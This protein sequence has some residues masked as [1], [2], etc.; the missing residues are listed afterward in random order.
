MTSVFIKIVNMSISASWLIL[1]IV[2][3]RA[4]FQKAPKKWLCALW[5]LVAFRLIFP[6]SIQ[7][8][9]SLMPSTETIPSNISSFSI[10]TIDSGIKVF[11]QT[12]DHFVSDVYK[13]FS[14]DRGNPLS[15]LLPIAEIIWVSGTFILLVY[16]LI[17]WLRL[18]KIVAASMPVGN[19]IRSI[20]GIRSPF[21]LGMIRPII[22]VPSYMNEHDLELVL[23]HEKAH[24]QR[25]DHWWKPLGFLLLSIYWFNPLCWLSYILLCRDI[26]MACDEKVIQ[27]MDREERATYSQVLLDCSV[28]RKQISICPLAFGETDIKTR[29]RE[30]LNYKSPSFRVLFLSVMAS[31]LLLT[32]LLTD[33]FTD[34]NLSEKLRVSLDHAVISHFQTSYNEG[35]YPTAEY[36]VFGIETDGNTTTVYAG[37]LY[38]EFA[39]INNTIFNANEISVPIAITFYTPKDNSTAFTYPVIDYWASSIVKKNDRDIMDRF[40]RK[41]LN[42]ALLYRS[43]D[44]MFKR[45]YQKAQEYYTPFQAIAK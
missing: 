19:Q 27:D 35:I 36:D 28:F 43:T 3:F 45:C 38:K 15:D 44:E 17:S 13:V 10:P 30:I 23:R 6:F 34:R 11:D 32:S 20:D 39:F 33:P 5:A 37:L 7:S 41:Y 12:F 22:Y 31:I 2:L 14:T 8:R 18:K 29:I 16:A 40:P 9:L 1:A 25:L 26:E 24:L 21:I 4:L 42:E